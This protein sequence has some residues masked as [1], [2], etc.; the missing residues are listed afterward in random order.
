MT[1]GPEELVDLSAE[2][3]NR[4]AAGVAVVTLVDSAGI[5]RGMTISSLTPVSSDPPS[6]LMC[7]GGKASARPHFVA[8]RTICA[9]VLASD[10]VPQSNGFA[11]GDADPFEVFEWSPTEDG[12]PVLAGTT[13]YLLCEVERVVDHHDTG[14]VLAKVT[15]GAV[16][17]DDSLVYWRRKYFGGLVPVEPEETGSW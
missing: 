11:F 9:N 17:A 12:T 7:I 14:V 13:A 15:G 6:V 4:V 2:V 8:G 3:M 10:Q 16:S 5:R 1:S